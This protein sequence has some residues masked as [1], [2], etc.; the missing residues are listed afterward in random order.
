MFDKNE[1]IFGSQHPNRDQQQDLGLLG[2]H[3][4]NRDELAVSGR[5]MCEIYAI[6]SRLLSPSD[7]IGALTTMR[8][9]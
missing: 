3:H 5:S 2:N 6:L 1:V 8:F 4:A 9:T 7:F